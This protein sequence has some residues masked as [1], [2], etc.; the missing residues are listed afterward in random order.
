MP[1]DREKGLESLQL[2]QH[3]VAFAAKVCQQVLPLLPGDE[4]WAMSA[5]LRRSVQSIPANIAEG[6]GR[7]YYQDCIRFCYIARGSLEETY[8]HLVLAKELNYLPAHVY[9]AMDRDVQEM[10]RLLNGYIAYLKR[11]KRGHNEPGAIRE[12]S[13]E[14]HLAASDAFSADDAP[15]E[16]LAAPAS[17]P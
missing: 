4:K 14:Y 8:S 16:H 3:A 12:A 6:F 5:Q 11:T 13:G 7:F 15:S 9:Q 17:D 1:E 2:W 10:R